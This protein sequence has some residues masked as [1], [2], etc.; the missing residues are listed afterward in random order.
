MCMGFVQEDM[1]IEY[2]FFNIVEDDL[3]KKYMQKVDKSK[4]ALN[5]VGS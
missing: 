1:Q 4:C 5:F 2:S 3:K